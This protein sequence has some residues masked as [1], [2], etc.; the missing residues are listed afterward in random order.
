ME[1][2]FEELLNAKRAELAAAK[3]APVV[4]SMNRFNRAVGAGRIW[5]AMEER[6]QAVRLYTD[7]KR[8]LGADHEDTQAAYTLMRDA[9]AACDGATDA[10]LAN[11]AR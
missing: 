9:M 7:T 2:T 8:A 5:A 3:A 10:G 11:L 1:P 6:A 4:R